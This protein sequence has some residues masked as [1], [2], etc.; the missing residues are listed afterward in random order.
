M[1]AT[2]NKTETHKVSGNV[3][4]KTGCAMFS[5]YNRIPNKYVPTVISEKTEAL[6]GSLDD[7][8]N[9]QAS[10]PTYLPPIIKCRHRSF[11]QRL[12]Y[13]QFK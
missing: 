6:E 4:R 5:R 13:H 3:F 1:V 9:N 12:G 11:S 10:V 8:S 7:E 2:G